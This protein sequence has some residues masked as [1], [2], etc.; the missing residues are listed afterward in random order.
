M[1]DFIVEL[2]GDIAELVIDL[3]IEP[4]ISKPKERR[5]QKKEKIKRKK[6]IQMSEYNHKAEEALARLKK[7]NQDY[8]NAQKTIGDI[9]QERRKQTLYNGQHPYAMIITCSDSRVIPE[10]IFSAGI[11][12]LFVIR[13]A[14]NVIDSHQL[15]SIEYAVEHLG[16]PLLVVLGHTNCG[17]IEAAIHHE[18]DGYIKFITDEIAKA[19]GEET[20]T[21][22]ACRLNI[23]HSQAMIEQAFQEQFEQDKHKSNFHT[24]RIVA[25]IYHLE[26]GHV[27]FLDDKI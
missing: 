26:D 15:G 19:I 22:Q 8:L 24:I 25:A 9:S 3:L 13:V 1:I 12:D 5:K 16:S 11:G 27:E 14:G 21:Y 4:Q 23:L 20:D 18:P 2:I 6:G 17:A 10:A 7:G